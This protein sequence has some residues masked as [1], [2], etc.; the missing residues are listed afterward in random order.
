M[1]KIVLTMMVLAALAVGNAAQ[2]QV[3]TTMSVTNIQGF[4]ADS[5]NTNLL[6]PGWT[7]TGNIYTSTHIFAGWGTG[8]HWLGG[9]TGAQPW[10]VDFSLGGT[11]TVDE[12]HIWNLNSADAFQATSTTMI[13]SQDATFGNGDDISVVQALS[14][15][16][17]GNAYTG[18]HFTLTPMA[19]VTHVRVEVIGAGSFVGLS[20]VRFSAVPEPSSFAL[21]A[22][23][24]VA[25]FILRRRAQ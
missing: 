3:I 25:L 1:K 24:G 19:N 10:A 18:E 20:E 4:N 22:L 17:G 5:L 14:L 7:D 6:G 13:F 21:M 23:G 8:N 11:Y 2:A 12:A 16:T 15:P 9:S